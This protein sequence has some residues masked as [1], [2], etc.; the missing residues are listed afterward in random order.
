MSKICI[1]GAWYESRNAGDQAILMT[2]AKLLS[3]RLSELDLVVFS[4]QPRFTQTYMQSVYPIRAL[5]HR[6]QLVSVLRELITCDLFIIGGG[7]PFYD[8]WFHLLAMLLLI[9]TT[10]LAGKPVMTYAVS[11]RPISS[12]AGKILTKLNLRL[13]NKITVREPNALDILQRLG[14]DKSISLFIDPAVTIR[15][16]NKEHILEIMNSEGIEIGEI[17]IV[18]ICPHFF[19]TS[20]SYRVHHYEDLSG[21][22]INRYH[23]VLAKTA[24]WLAFGYQVLFIPMNTEAPDDDR[25]TIEIVKSLMENYENCKV[26]HNQYGPRELAG[27]F[28]NCEMVLAVRLHGSV[29]A[30][31][32][33]T[34]IIAISYGPKVQG[35]MERIGQSKFVFNLES[36][37]INNMIQL[38]KQLLRNKTA[39]KQELTKVMEEMSR[40]AECNADTAVSLFRDGNFDS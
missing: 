31:S 2:I 22:L 19:S 30:S 34:P 23:H 17:P 32:V 26:I 33:N 12:I 20:D 14:G 9:I 29:L 8:D 38:T 5:S 7:T 37:Q 21:K 11:A 4:N 13:I 18:A 24:D 36:I 6:H 39:I 35:Y 15:P 3:Q 28:N 1:W 25:I 16:T 10:R 40:I 27:I